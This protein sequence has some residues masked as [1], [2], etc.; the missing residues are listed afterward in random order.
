MKTI[1]SILFL[2]AI[3]CIQV[4][5]GPWPHVKVPKITGTV[6]AFTWVGGFHFQEED[7]W[8]G[9][10]FVG[11]RE[12]EPV[13]H[14]LLNKTNLSAETRKTLTEYGENA[15]FRPKMYS[16]RGLEDEE[17]ILM[18]DSSRLKEIVVGAQIT[19]E[20]Y[21]I[22][23]DEFTSWVK[24]QRFLVDGKS[25]T[26]GRQDDDDDAPASDSQ[27][28]KAEQ[29]ATKPADIRQDPRILSR[30]AMEKLPALAVDLNADGGVSIDGEDF[31]LTQL[32][33]IVKQLMKIEPNL[34]LH[35]RGTRDQILHSRP[36][37]RAAASGGLDR[38]LF[39]P[40]DA[41]KEKG[42]KTNK[43]AHPTAISRF[44]EIRL[45]ARRRL[46]QTFAR[47]QCVP[48]P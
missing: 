44:V 17:V 30:E 23:A 5:A 32:T 12:A 4:T 25:P 7:V 34:V 42:A 36:V 20:D 15:N 10:N 39:M 29:P 37:V 38:V 41:P 8:Q 6:V 16:S 27:P 40:V 13:Y 1:A 11:M 28:K 19:I 47:K 45:P 48:L 43:P 35:I 2:G 22:A 46:P 9:V 26:E 33:V 18:I 31:T 14:L 3:L 21:D 24:H